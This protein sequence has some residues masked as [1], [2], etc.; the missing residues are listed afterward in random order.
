MR[1]FQTIRILRGSVLGRKVEIKT[2]EAVLASPH[3]LLLGRSVDYFFSWNDGRREWSLDEEF[4]STRRETGGFQGLLKNIGRV[5]SE[6][7]HNSASLGH[8]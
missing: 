4:P 1:K 8:L 6:P 7:D 5:V 3:H 2:R